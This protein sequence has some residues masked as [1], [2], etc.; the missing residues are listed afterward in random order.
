M[1]Q[2]L[3]PFCFLFALIMAGVA[4]S[5][6]AIGSPDVGVELHQARATNDEF[7]KD[8]LESD[9][10]RKQWAHSLMIVGL[11]ASSVLMIVVGFQSMRKS[12]S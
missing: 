5:L 1:R 9:L 10:S 4:F 2:L 12:V 6:L 7:F 3:P 8:A 11:L